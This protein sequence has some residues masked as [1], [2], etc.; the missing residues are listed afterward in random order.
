MASR[1]FPL[2]NIEQPVGPGKANLPDDVRLVQALFIEVS[3]FDAY[4]WVQDIPAQFRTLTT[5][6]MWDDNLKEWVL[7]FQRWSAK[8]FGGDANF[9]VDGIVDPMPV[10]SIA[11]SPRFPSRRIS[12]LAFLCNRVWR[13]NRDVYLRIGDDYKVPW[14]PRGWVDQGGRGG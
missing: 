14:V 5:S 6:G 10:E 13:W 2:Y 11:V 7:A 4:D 9:K 8:G 1:F 12:I 3:R